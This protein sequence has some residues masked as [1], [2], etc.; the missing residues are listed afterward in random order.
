MRITIDIDDKELEKLRKQ[1]QSQ[2]E[3]EVWPKKADNGWVDGIDQCKNCPNNPLN[4]N[5]QNY[6]GFCMCAIPSLYGPNR[7]IC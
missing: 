1:H 4:P 5:G 6:G 2:N 7:V 3:I